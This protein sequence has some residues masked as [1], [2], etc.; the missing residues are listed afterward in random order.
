MRGRKARSPEQA[1]PQVSARQ[2]WLG[3]RLP[4]KQGLTDPFYEMG[5]VLLK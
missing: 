4:Q 3:S 2:T 1:R 5:V